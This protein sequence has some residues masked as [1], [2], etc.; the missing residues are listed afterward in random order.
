MSHLDYIKVVLFSIFIYPIKMI[1]ALLDNVISAFSVIKICDSILAYKSNTL[2]EPVKV[3]LY[4]TST[5]LLPAE[6]SSP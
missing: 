5:E 4:Q 1:N 3:D 6:I 2:R